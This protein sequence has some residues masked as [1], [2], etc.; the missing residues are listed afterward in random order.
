M[1]T[2]V[3]HPV[4]RSTQ[5]RHAATHQTNFVSAHSRK[6]TRLTVSASEAEQMQRSR[7]LRTVL[8]VSLV[9]LVT[10]IALGAGISLA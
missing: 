7:L 4:N 10:V 2:T 8:S 9:S 3:F 6:A 5:R 1:Q